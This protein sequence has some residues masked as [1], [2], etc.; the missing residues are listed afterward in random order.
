MNGSVQK[1]D[2]TLSADV[3]AHFE[4]ISESLVHFRSTF[5]NLLKF[6][7]LKCC[8]YKYISDVMAIFSP[9]F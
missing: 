8:L 2:S 7:V 5:C 6:D 9:P 3:K 4:D 1:A